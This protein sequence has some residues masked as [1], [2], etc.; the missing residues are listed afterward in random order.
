MREAGSTVGGG[1][2]AGGR[3]QTVFSSSPDCLAGLSFARN[4]FPKR[5]Y[6]PY[7]Y[8]KVLISYWPVSH[9]ESQTEHARRL[10]LVYRPPFLSL[11]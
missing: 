7:F 9:D 2:R 6:N 3:G 11:N 10:D 8:G 4:V 1:G 5:S